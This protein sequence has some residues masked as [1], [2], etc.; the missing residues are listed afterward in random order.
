MMERRLQRKFNGRSCF[1]CMVLASNSG[2]RDRAGSGAESGAS[3]ASNAPSASSA[4]NAPSD[5]GS[6]VP[7]V[8]PVQGKGGVGPA[9]GDDGLCGGEVALEE[10]QPY[11]PAKKGAALPPQSRMVFG[12]ATGTW[13]IT[14]GHAAS[15]FGL[16]TFAAPPVAAPPFAAGGGYAGFSTPSFAP[17]CPRCGEHGYF[18][19]NCP[20][21]KAG[22]TAHA[23]AHATGQAAA[24]KMGAP[25]KG[26][27]AVGPAPYSPY[28]PY[29]PYAP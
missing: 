29:A 8:A 26:A 13:P 21:A 16:S 17:P 24:S 19:S 5:S 7:R 2:G 18:A 9:E 11:Q 25:T 10:Q 22:A 14:T 15:D 4:P 6:S 3:S 23:T 28:P 20:A 12:T 1:A 27:S